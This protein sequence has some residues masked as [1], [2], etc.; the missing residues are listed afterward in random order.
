MSDELD[1]GKLSDRELLIVL[2]TQMS[3]HLKHHDMYTKIA[4]SAGLIGVINFTI[5][6]LLIVI[7][8][9]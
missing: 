5:A 7:K 3:N 6:L 4:L 2:H 9:V 8:V 1:L